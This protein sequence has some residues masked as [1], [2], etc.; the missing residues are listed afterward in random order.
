[1]G[2]EI[3]VNYFGMIAEKLEKSSEKLIF[4]DKSIELKPFLEEIHPFLREFTYSIAVDLK[5]SEALDEKQLPN[6]IDIMPPFA[7]G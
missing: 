3:T 6:K 7:G 2:R 1:M 5:F 4:P